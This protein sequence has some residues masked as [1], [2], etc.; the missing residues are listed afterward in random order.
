METTLYQPHPALQPYIQTYLYS[1]VGGGTQ[2]I[3]LDLF[4][5]GHGVLA[6]IL[7]EEHFLHNPQLNK[8]YN[9]RF[10]FTGQLD[11]YVHLRA[12][13][14]T[15]IYIMFRPY[16]AYQLLGIPQYL[17]I[18]ECT[19]MSDILNDRIN[20]LC[21][22]M[23]DHTTSPTDVLQ[24]LENWLLQQ[25]E[26]NK[27][28]NTDRIAYAC[29]EIISSNGSLPVKDLYGLVNMSKS[30]LEQHFRQQVGLSPKMFSRVI[31]FNQVNKFLRETATS[32]WQELVY[33]YGYFD[34]SHFIH[35]F[36]H[37]FGYSPSQVHLSYH[38]LTNHVTSL[39]AE[40]DRGSI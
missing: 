35:E 34:Q 39:G 1:R 33:R 14:A 17:L 11:K 3:E 9:V 2:R 25:L 40:T 18:N 28:L 30:S 26:K 37:F 36:R 38:N 32:D 10:N 13:S 31:R 21:R 7:S 24:L 20:E 27:K 15:M 22:K 19:C 12:S 8:Y 29:N 4:P 5:V 23:E 16:G 6:F